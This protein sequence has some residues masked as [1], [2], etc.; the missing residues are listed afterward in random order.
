VVGGLLL[1]AGSLFMGVMPTPPGPGT[2]AFLLGLGMIAGESRPVARILDR[3]EVGAR[4]LDRRVGGVWGPSAAGKA[5]V[6]L[7]AA[8]CSA[9]MLFGA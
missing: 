2:V 8:S 5:L 6:V 7:V 9:A 1:V 3:G 4:G